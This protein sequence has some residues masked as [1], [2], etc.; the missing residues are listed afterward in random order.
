[1]NIQLKKI[2]MAGALIAAASA[3]GAQAADQDATAAEAQDQGTTVADQRL[4]NDVMT[5]ISSDSSLDGQISVQ[6]KDGV[7]TLSGLV[8]TEG[9][10]RQA[11]MDAENVAGVREVDNGV[12]ALVGQNF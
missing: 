6:A 3:L 4:Q 2:V 8:T 9:Q 11:G 10:A 12:N 5:A 7:V 1:M